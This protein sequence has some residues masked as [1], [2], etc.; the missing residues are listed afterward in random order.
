MGAKVGKEWNKA[1]GTE[2]FYNF[3]VGFQHRF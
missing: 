2:N 1:T 3:A